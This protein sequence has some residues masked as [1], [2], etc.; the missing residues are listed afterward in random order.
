MVLQKYYIGVDVAKETLDF[1]L[2]HEG[3]LFTHESIKN[4]KKAIKK[5]LCQWSKEY[6]FDFKEV[7]TC[8]EHTG[9]YSY[10]LIQYLQETECKICIESAYNIKHSNGLQRG[11]ND[12]IDAERIALYGWRNR[13]N[14]KEWKAPAEIIKQLKQLMNLRKNLLK[15]K[16]SLELFTKEMTGFEDK[17]IVK[18]QKQNC[19]KSIKAL[20]SDIENIEQKI[21]VLLKSDEELMKIYHI[22]ISV[23]GIGN[24]TAVMLIVTTNAFTTFTEGKKFACYAGVVPFEHTS[25]KSIRGR[26]KVSHFANKEIKTALHMCALSASYGKGELGEYY[27]RKISEGKNKMSVINAVRN[28]IVLR[29]FACVKNNKMYDKNQHRAG[30]A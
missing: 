25:G 8:M 9:I 19:N 21:M 26:N 11:K 6:E 16:K 4:E 12:K 30:V 23:E 28:K 17:N 29:V 18:D 1:A 3:K 2:V 5:L 24:V 10:N 20:I 14:L 7:L 13:E 27:Q 15:C 22:L